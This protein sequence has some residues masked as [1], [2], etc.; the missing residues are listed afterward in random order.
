MA[1]SK[2]SDGKDRAEYTTDSAPDSRRFFVSSR[3]GG[4]AL[5]TKTRRPNAAVRPQ[6]YIY[7]VVR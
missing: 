3:P 1:V 6:R 4:I 5:T 7:F 2:G